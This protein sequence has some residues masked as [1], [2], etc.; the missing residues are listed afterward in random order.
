MNQAISIFLRM[1]RHGEARAL[2]DRFPWRS[3]LWRGLIAR[4]YGAL[5]D[6]EQALRI[7]REIES[8][9][10]PAPF[11]DIALA[12][13]YLGAGDTA[14][15][16]DALERSTTA[17][18]PWPTHTGLSEPS[19]DPVRSSPRFAALVRRVGLDERVFTRPAARS[20]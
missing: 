16:L 18:E 12:S 1:G 5:G 9:R 13:A 19:F 17:G 15:A 11:A 6:R 10:P 4:A 8:R 20:P 14:R 2:A 3:T 7:A